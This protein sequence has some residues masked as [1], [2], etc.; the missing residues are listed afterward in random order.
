[1]KGRPLKLP[2]LF[3]LI[4]TFII[5][6]SILEAYST[7]I[8]ISEVEPLPRRDSTT[9]FLS[10]YTGRVGRFNFT[11]ETR[12]V[13]LQPI[14]D[15]VNSAVITLYWTVEAPTG[16]D[17]RYFTIS[18]SLYDDNGVS[19]TSG[20]VTVC[21]LKGTN[22]GSYTIP[23]SSTNIDDVASVETSITDKGWC[24]IS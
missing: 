3:F 13:E 5:L 9:Y 10:K 19:L 7:L 22:S 2:F 8:T 15:Y 12:S 20:S 23:L 18:V 1:M 17:G 11:V 16:Q 4:I 14:G 24:K 21:L 6:F